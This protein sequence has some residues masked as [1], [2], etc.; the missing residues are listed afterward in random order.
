M[1]N[2]F[3]PLMS[4][5]ITRED[6]DTLINFLKQNPIP[7]LTNGSKVREFEKMVKGTSTLPDGKIEEVYL[8]NWTMMVFHIFGIL[9][10]VARYYHQKYNLSFVRFYE[11]LMEYFKNTKGLF[12]QEFAKAQAKAK[13][14][15][16]G[17]GWDHYD[18]SLGDV[19]WPIEEASWLRLVRNKLELM[20]ELCGF[21][22][23]LNNALDLERAD[24]DEMASLLTFQTFVLNF[25]EDRTVKEVKAN[26]QHDWINYFINRASL[27]EQVQLR[28]KKQNKIKEQDLIKWGYEAVWFGRR[29]QK[30]K[31]GL[32]ELSKV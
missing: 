3:L 19:S 7:Q 27:P 9:E 5:N 30:Y 28:L 32:E 25:P 1:A 15:Y 11:M 31:M 12:A 4:D 14:G 18:E 8:F 24:T 6:V 20:K 21:V 26:V 29:S 22:V 17:K 16:S 10:F 2:F 13:E 23:F